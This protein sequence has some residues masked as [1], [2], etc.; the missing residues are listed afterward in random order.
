[1]GFEELQREAFDDSSSNSLLQTFGLRL[2]FFQ[3][4]DGCK[5]S[6]TFGAFGDNLLAGGE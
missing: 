4:L 2:F 6:E 3:D 1:M 5:R